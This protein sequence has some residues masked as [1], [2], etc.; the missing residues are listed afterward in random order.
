MKSPSAWLRNELYHI[1]IKCAHVAGT[2][3]MFTV[4]SSS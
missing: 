4:C 2:H 3:I 1:D